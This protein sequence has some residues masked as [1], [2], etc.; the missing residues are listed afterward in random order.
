VSAY[1]ETQLIPTK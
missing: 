1:I